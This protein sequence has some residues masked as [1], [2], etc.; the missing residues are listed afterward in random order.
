VNSKE[1]L[2]LERHLHHI[3]ILINGPPKIVLLAIDLYK[4][5]IIAVTEIEAIVEP[6]CITDDVGWE[7]V[8]LVCI[9]RPIP[10]KSAS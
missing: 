4:D 2:G 8:M 1:T 10:L 7:S 9:H 3:T 5:F 6:E